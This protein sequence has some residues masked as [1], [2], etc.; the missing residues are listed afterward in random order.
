MIDTT[1]YKSNKYLLALTFPV[2][3][4]V[5]L[6]M[7]I[8]NVDQFM[9]MS[10]SEN[11][12]SAIGNVNQLIN[13]FILSFNIVAMSSTV[14]IAQYIGA[15]DI[16]RSKK[17]YSLSVFVNTT[18]GLFVTAVVLIFYKPIF[19]W[20]EYPTAIIDD[21]S[22]YIVLI[23]SCLVFNALGI[24]FAS[25]FKA[26]GLMKEWMYISLLANIVNVTGN[27]LLLYGWFGLPKLGIVGVAI[28]SNV[29]KIFAFL[30]VYRLYKK[31]IGHTISIKML[32]PFPI[33]Q[34]KKML[35]IGVPSAG[36]SMCFSLM[37]IVIQKFINGFGQAMVTARVTVN[38]LSFVSW[39]FATAI[40]STT[41]V[42]VGYL[43]GAKDIEG[44]N[45]RFWSSL[46]L[47]MLCTF[48]GSLILFFFCEPI[49]GIFIKDPEVLA[50]CKNIMF[51]EIFLEQGRAINLSCVRSLQACGDTKF[52][53]ITGIISSWTVAVGLG[54][55][56]GVV[57]NFGIVGVWIGMAC[58]E[59]LRG[60]IFTM[61]WKRGK[62]RKMT[63]VEVDT[64]E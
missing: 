57:L 5:L 40:S 56:L 10:Y 50:V 9:I 17:I 12:Y 63:L 4:E 46:R 18:F 13:F 53:I 29:S 38:L 59:L 47:S 19:R 35:G 34:F 36:E 1:Q 33:H 26:N 27:A 28:S 30:V 3:I 23:G 11:A 14:L 20:L 45:K 55:L 51:V 48:I 21:A 41:Q 52:P 24:T 58:D 43:M 32:K 7:L 39:I 15:K 6:N 42:V 16:E 49:F 60:M 62:W 22:T 61:R 37:T 2:F 31:K 64:A 54:Y 8:G 25:F 44:T